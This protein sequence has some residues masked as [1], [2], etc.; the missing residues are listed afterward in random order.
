MQW[1]PN[2]I[3]HSNL[4]PN[5]NIPL[6]NSIP[7]K[8]HMK[9]FPS[10]TK[11]IKMEDGKLENY[12]TMNPQMQNYSSPK[13]SFHPRNIY[14]NGLI[15]GYQN[16]MPYKIEK[17][18]VPP[19][20]M[21]HKMQETGSIKNNINS[22]S[23]FNINTMTGNINMPNPS[24]SL[25]PIFAQQP[26]INQNGVIP[27]AIPQIH[28]YPFS[29]NGMIP[30]PSFNFQSFS[31]NLQVYN[32][33]SKPETKYFNSLRI[34]DNIHCANKLPLGKYLQ[35]KF[36][37]NKRLGFATV[38]E[39]I[40]DHLI[41]L[42]K[43]FLALNGGADRNIWLTLYSDKIQSE[44]NA[45]DDDLENTAQSAFRASLNKFIKVYNH[46][47]LKPMY[48]IC[49]LNLNDNISITQEQGK[50]SVRAQNFS[51]KNANSGLESP[52]QEKKANQGDY[53]F[54]ESHPFNINNS[55]VNNNFFNP[56]I[57]TQSPYY[58]PTPVPGFLPHNYHPLSYYHYQPILF[59]Q[60]VGN[61][62]GTN[63]ERNPNIPPLYKNYVYNNPYTYN[64]YG[65]V[66]NNQF[67][68]MNPNFINCNIQSNN[69]DSQQN[70][71]MPQNEF[72]E[73]SQ[74]MEGEYEDDNESLIKKS[75]K[76]KRG[77]KKETKHLA[78]PELLARETFNRLDYSKIE[79]GSEFY[80]KI[81]KN[82]CFNLKELLQFEEIVDEEIAKRSEKEIIVDLENL[83]KYSTFSKYIDLSQNCKADFKKEY[84][85]EIKNFK[86]NED[87]EKIMLLARRTGNIIKL[88]KDNFELICSPKE[89]EN[90]LKT[91]RSYKK[92]KNMIIYKNERVKNIILDERAKHTQLNK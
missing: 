63:D 40:P 68:G 36:L 39:H 82:F 80:N 77:R 51:P 7:D 84:D 91:N 46:K 27:N 41:H 34:L 69:K 81:S 50:S 28:Q 19:E 56:K 5:F 54:N 55:N 20:P 71:N 32:P 17:T 15:L 92:V 43:S 31:P 57:S 62:I 61:F 18:P 66:S 78:N 44:K 2:M 13:N 9:P 48:F 38:R 79:K 75:M 89:V 67:Q 33:D 11:N 14:Q 24:P 70:I 59:Q 60:N 10:E 30:F 64:F 49:K 37:L 88:M 45:I 16:H 23:P 83:N 72:E 47:L 53:Q 73:N 21:E 3:P 6:A 1:N 25:Y 29:V 35:L 65:N 22:N 26:Y 76:K 4:Y 58:I 42:R 85:E 52:K 74:E 12:P 90:L 87:N 86:S 8:I